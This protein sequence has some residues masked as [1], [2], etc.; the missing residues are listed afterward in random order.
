M[1]QSRVPFGSV[2]GVDVPCSGAL[3]SLQQPQVRVPAPGPLLRVAPP[4]SHPVPCHL[5]NCHI[6]AQKILKKIK[7]KK[8]CLSPRTPELVNTKIIYK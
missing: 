4:L 3:S 2:G 1:F 6:K 5:L 8:T 7:I